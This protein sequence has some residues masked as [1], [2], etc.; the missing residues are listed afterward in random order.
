MGSSGGCGQARRGPTF[1]SPS[2]RTP[3][4]QLSWSGIRS[5]GRPLSVAHA[6]MVL[7]NNSGASALH[8]WPTPGTII[9]TQPAIDCSKICKD[10]LIVACSFSPARIRVRAETFARSGL[11]SNPMASFPTCR[12]VAAEALAPPPRRLIRRT[13]VAPRARAIFSRTPSKF[14]IHDDKAITIL[15]DLFMAMGP[16]WNPL[17]TAWLTSCGW[18]IRSRRPTYEPIEMPTMVTGPCAKAPI[19]A[20]TRSA[21]SSNVVKGTPALSPCPGKSIVVLK[22][23]GR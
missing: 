16:L 15:M 12:V 14:I 4:D 18:R 17:N 11:A 21:A 9:A 10:S 5:F 8:P 22:H 6:R 19:T 7:A 20:A 2:D 23:S 1:R 13:S 3:R